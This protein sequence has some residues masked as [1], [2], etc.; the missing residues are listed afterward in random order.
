MCSSLCVKA[1]MLY[2]HEWE[3][4]NQ[5]LMDPA[6]IWASDKHLNAADKAL[7]DAVSLLED[8]RPSNEVCVMCW[9]VQA[10]EKW[11]ENMSDPRPLSKTAT[12]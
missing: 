10:G 12:A 8:A 5:A 1:S 7:R 2:N 6:C 11:R 4:L 9:E 3:H